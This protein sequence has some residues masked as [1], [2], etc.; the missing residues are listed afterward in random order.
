LIMS[1]R[2]TLNIQRASTVYA[3]ML[4]AGILPDIAT[5]N[6]LIEIHCSLR[7]FDSAWQL[8]NDPM[9]C[10]GI[11]PNAATLSIMVRQY[12]RAGM[13]D[14]V[15]DTIVRLGMRVEEPEVFHSIIAAF[16][17][18]GNLTTALAILQYMHEA[19]R[20]P[21]GKSYQ[22]LM[23]EYMRQGMAH[24]VVALSRLMDDQRAP[25][26]EVA[27]RL[28]IRARQYMHDDFSR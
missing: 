19:K 25:Y 10:R 1:Y 13:I 3:D 2:A 12:C 15:F 28:A 5:Y 6:L 23:Q 11:Q 27:R 22:L 9:A 7:E 18:K 16:C 26:T 20:R 17:E 14:Q 8:I 4:A 24:Q 21:L